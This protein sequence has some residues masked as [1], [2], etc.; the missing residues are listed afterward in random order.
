MTKWK[1][2]ISQD[3]IN[4]LLDI[5]GGFHDSCIV[6]VSYKSGAFVDD[7]QAMHFGGPSERE[8]LVVFHRQWKPQILE[9]CFTGL[10]Q[11]HLTGWQNNYFCDI[12]DAHLSFY[13]GLLPG[14]PERVIVW[15]DYWDFDVEKINN[16]IHE[17][18]DTY[19]IANAMKLRIIYSEGEL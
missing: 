8:L 10:R 19:I 15:A 11:L 7:K 2:V 13:K 4:S 12:L 9:M 3:D 1:E 17:P 16:A 5:Y 18:S 6:S 14:D